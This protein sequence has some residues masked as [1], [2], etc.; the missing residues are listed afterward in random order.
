VRCIGTGLIPRPGMRRKI[1][2]NVRVTNWIKKKWS[3]V[4]SFAAGIE[5]GFLPLEPARY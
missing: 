4:Q 3:C 1:T 2:H 5:G